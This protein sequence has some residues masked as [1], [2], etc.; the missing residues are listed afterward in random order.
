ML[1]IHPPPQKS[2]LKL[3]SYHSSLPSKQLTHPPR[4]NYFHHH[5]LTSNLQWN[6]LE[7]LGSI[8]PSHLPDPASYLLFL[9][10]DQ[11]RTYDWILLS[12][13]LQFDS[14]APVLLL[15]LPLL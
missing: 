13:N 11:M 12:R 10:S 15:L 5:I 2:A 9:P 1:L 7:P 4:W 6:L 3:L 14:L 8:P